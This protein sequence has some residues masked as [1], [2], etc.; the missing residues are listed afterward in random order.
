GAEWDTPFFT[1]FTLFG[2]V[3]HNGPMYLNAG[4]TQ[5]IPDWTRLDMGA[6]YMFERSNGKLITCVQIL[7]MYSVKTTGMRMLSVNLP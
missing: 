2:R 5:K 4:N 3:T 1:G 6:R 7:I